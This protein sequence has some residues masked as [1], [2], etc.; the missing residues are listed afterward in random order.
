MSAGYLV[1]K[2]AWARAANPQ[3]HSVLEL[4][5]ETRSLA[6]CAITNLEVLYSARSSSDYGELSD[7]LAGLADVPIDSEHMARALE[8]QRRLAAK[9]RHRLPIPDL[10][11]AATAESSGLSV[12]HYD[13]DYERIAEVTHQSNQWVVPRGSV[14]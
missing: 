7:E 2:S 5:I 10:I 12:L 6:T 13:A 11:I 1:D 14:P 9:G 4:L 3:V 8:V